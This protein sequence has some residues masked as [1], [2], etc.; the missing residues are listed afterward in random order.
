MSSRK[1]TLRKNTANVLN[2]KT[3][4]KFVTIN[5]SVSLSDLPYLQTQSSYEWTAGFSTTCSCKHQNDVLLLDSTVD[6]FRPTARWR[7]RTESRQQDLETIC[8]NTD[9]L[10][11][12]LTLHTAISRQKMYV[13]IFFMNY[14]SHITFYIVYKLY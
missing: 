2:A 10:I 4:L 8:S 11:S 14:T 5:T 9:T 1:F 3:A 12:F 7:C 13:F 6:H